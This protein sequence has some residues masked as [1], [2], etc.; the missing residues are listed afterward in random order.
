MSPTLRAMSVAD[1]M[2]V[3]AYAASL[4]PVPGVAGRR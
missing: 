1:L 3:S 4:D 2:A